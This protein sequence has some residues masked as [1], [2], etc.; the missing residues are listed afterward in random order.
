[1]I[2][3]ESQTFGECYNIGN[4]IMIEDSQ[5]CMWSDIFPPAAQLNML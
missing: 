4:R 3:T 5:E 2:Q 1:M